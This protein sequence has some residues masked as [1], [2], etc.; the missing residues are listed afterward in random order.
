MT[1]KNPRLTPYKEYVFSNLPPTVSSGGGLYNYQEL[2]SLVGLKPT[3]NFR[4]RVK[5]LVDCG[6]L[7]C[8][9]VFTPRGGIEARFTT[10]QTVE[11]GDFPF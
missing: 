7:R 8:V 4:R 9:A 1:P 10:P 5:E 3:N 2:A 11:I 6:K